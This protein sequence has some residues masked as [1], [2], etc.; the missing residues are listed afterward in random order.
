MW[1]EKID[2]NL[3]YFYTPIMD[4][5]YLIRIRKILGCFFVVEVFEDFSDATFEAVVNR[6]CRLLSPLPLPLSAMKKGD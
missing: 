5:S 6:G 3:I 1:D 2:K 4:D